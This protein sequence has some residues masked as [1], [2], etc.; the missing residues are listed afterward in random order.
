M[1]DA[2]RAADGPLDAVAAA[3]ARVDAAQAVLDDLRAQRNQAAARAVRAGAAHREV[4]AAAR[5]SRRDL[6]MA[7]DRLRRAGGH[8]RVHAQFER[9]L[10]LA[11]QPA[12]SPASRP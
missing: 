5:M 9:R 1:D 7:L 6:Q 8:S 3:A 11:R 2:R 10:R 12:S 4:I